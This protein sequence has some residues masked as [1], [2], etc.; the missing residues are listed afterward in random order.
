MI[1]LFLIFMLFQVVYDEWI[2]NTIPWHTVY[3]GFLYLWVAAV[4]VVNAQKGKH[5]IFYYTFA[6]IMLITASWKIFQPEKQAE[7]LSKVSPGISWFSIA[8]ILLLISS[9]IKWN[10]LKT[11]FGRRSL[12]H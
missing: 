10:G 1:Y 3:F 12:L 9:L 6:L 2:P 7:E 5:Y 11:I 8:V 4:S